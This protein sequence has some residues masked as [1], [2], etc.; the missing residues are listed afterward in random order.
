LGSIRRCVLVATIVPG[1]FRKTAAPVGKSGGVDE[2]LARRPAGVSAVDVGSNN[3]RLRG[4]K[5][6]TG[7]LLLAGGVCL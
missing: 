5:K 7:Q 6:D 4:M 1:D 2:H 3:P